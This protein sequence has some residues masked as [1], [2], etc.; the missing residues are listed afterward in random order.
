[1]ASRSFKTNRNLAQYAAKKVVGK[2][3][4][5]ADISDLQEVLP[6]GIQMNSFTIFGE[7][8]PGN[9]DEYPTTTMWQA[10]NNVQLVTLDA[11]EIPGTIY[12]A[13]SGSDFGGE[14]TPQSEGPHAWYLKL[15]DDY[16][17]NSAGQFPEVGFDQFVN[18]QIMYTTL[19]TLQ[20]VPT[21][22][23]INPANPALNPYFPKIYTWDGQTEQSKS[24]LPLGPA[25][26]LDWFFDPFNGVVFFQ[27]YDGRV[28]YKVE[29]YIYVG[30]FSN[31]TGGGG[32][33]GS[34]ADAVSSVNKLVHE[35]DTDL[36]AT[37]PFTLTGFDFEFTPFASEALNVFL[38]GQL[39]VH[40][41]DTEFTANS[42][43]YT[44]TFNS[45]ITDIKFNMDIEVGDII[46]VTYSG[47]ASLAIKPIIT[48]EQDASM[49]NSVVL[50]AGDG[51]S[52]TKPNPTTLL[53]S[54]TGL[55]QRTKQHFQN[56]MTRTVDTNSVISFNNVD[57]SDLL[58]SDDRIDVLHEGRMLLKDIHY[59]LAD[60]D[61]SLAVSELKVIGDTFIQNGDYI[62]IILY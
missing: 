58:Y 43:D 30:K 29:C 45:N 44:V 10:A 33:G 47:G 48:F 41:D 20:A 16:E 4:T 27:E 36:A 53:V 8:V 9:P 34:S 38:N 56:T 60:F 35:F 31:D 15:P 7:K 22:M 39:L 12:D 26:Q 1:M 18:D 17:T 3:H 37:V 21:S 50:T 32:G 55:L 14:D 59:N 49:D 6:T 62:T 51:I 46:T 25:D 23:Y 24:S 11:V 61:S 54:N 57:F 28:P 13:D 52:I 40:G 19:G 2:A 42:V 5:R